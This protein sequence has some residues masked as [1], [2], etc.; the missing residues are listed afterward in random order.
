MLHFKKDWELN[1]EVP[2]LGPWRSVR[3]INNPIWLLERNPYLLRGRYG[4]QPVTLFRS[5]PVHACRNLEVINLRAMAGEYDEQERHIDL[6]KLPVL[7]DNQAKGTTRCIW[8]SALPDP[9][10][11]ST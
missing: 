3:P 10:S 6:G 2:V 5:D 11:C 4:R 1:T 9:T 8:T 7:L